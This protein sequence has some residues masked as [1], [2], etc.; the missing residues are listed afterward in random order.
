LNPKLRLW[1]SE[2]T[3]DEGRGNLNSKVSDH[4]VPILRSTIRVESAKGA[5]IIHTSLW[6]NDDAERCRICPESQCTFRE[7]PYGQG[8]CFVI[9]EVGQLADPL[10]LRG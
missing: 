4:P 9:I 3:V 8:Q 5:S 1:S 7:G 2:P 6:R 10:A